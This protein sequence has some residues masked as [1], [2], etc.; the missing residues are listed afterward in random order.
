MRT[1][2]A[3]L[4]FAIVAAVAIVAGPVAARSSTPI[5]IT[6]DVNLDS[7]VETIT[8]QTNFC[9][10]TAESDAWFSGG[11]RNGGGTVVFHVTKL[12]TCAGGEDT[13]L[14]ELQAA[15]NRPKGG[16]TGGWTVIE[17]DRRLCGRAWRRQHRRRVHRDRDHGP[18]RGHDRPLTPLQPRGSRGRAPRPDGWAKVRRSSPAAT[19]SSGSIAASPAARTIASSDARAAGT[20]RSASDDAL[21]RPTRSGPRPFAEAA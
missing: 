12:F 5:S 9:A 1:R 14:V 2:T 16:T 17:R 20:S 11:G 6:L 18:V 8:D 19:A 15:S 3:S 13:L 21:A 10:G 4:A 7:G